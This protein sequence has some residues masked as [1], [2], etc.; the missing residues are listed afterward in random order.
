MS[1]MSAACDVCSVAWLQCTCSFRAC[2][3]LHPRQLKL[4]ILQSHI[5]WQ[6]LNSASCLQCRCLLQ[7]ASASTA[8]GSTH[9]CWTGIAPAQ[10]SQLSPLPVISSTYHLECPTESTKVQVTGSAERLQALRLLGWLPPPKP[11]AV[12]AQSSK[13]PPAKP[14]AASDS[15]SQAA[16]APATL[17]GAVQSPRH[18][19]QPAEAEE[20][21]Q[22]Q[23]KQVI[24]FSRCVPRPT[25]CAESLHED[26]T[27]LV[28]C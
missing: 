21:E 14:K 24:P 27:S 13:T 18:A 7:R 20:A 11:R 5:M 23:N 19:E 2:S 16:A 12:Q 28:F 25:D 26:D 8:C 6:V 15:G 1:H 9:N 4:T 17:E 3:C 10:Q 22:M